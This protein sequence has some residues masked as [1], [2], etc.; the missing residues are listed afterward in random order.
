MKILKKG[1]DKNIWWIGKT[2]TCK[3]CGQQAQLEA[4]DSKSIFGF[5]IGTDYISFD[6]ANCKSNVTLEKSKA[7][8][9]EECL[10]Q[11]I[12]NEPVKEPIVE[13]TVTAETVQVAPPASTNTGAAHVGPAKSSPGWSNPFKGTSWEGKPATSLG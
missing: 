10:K 6:C 3:E 4:T 5:F 9:L 13:S 8:I 11:P 12:S 1:D 7:E 2:A